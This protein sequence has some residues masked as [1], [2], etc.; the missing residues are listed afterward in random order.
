MLSSEEVPFKVSTLTERIDKMSDRRLQIVP[1]GTW[2]THLHLLEPETFPYKSNRLYT[3][4]G[5]GLSELMSS[6]VADRFLVVQASVED[7]TGGILSHLQQAREQY[8]DKVFRAEIEIP[9]EQTYTDDELKHLNEIGVRAIRLHGVLGWDPQDVTQGIKHE[10]S[11]LATYA[12][13]SGWFLSSMCSL[14]TWNEL[15]EW[16]A[17]CPEVQA[18]KII[19]EHSA[20]IDPSRNGADY[21]E[22]DSLLKFLAQYPNKFFVKICGLNRLESGSDIA[23]KSSRVPSPIIAMIR[24][25]PNQVMWGFRLASY[26]L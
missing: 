19:I 13:R 3:P 21:P 15:S 14:K 17:T 9:P 20:R 11:R 2:D 12:K 22:L 16:L 26:M 4:V 8:P 18:V 25:L 7:G 23:G 5:A 10:F 6:T 1:V 24:A